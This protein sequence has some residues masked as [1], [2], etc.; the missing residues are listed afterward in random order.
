MGCHWW[1]WTPWWALWPV[2]ELS[3]EVIGFPLSTPKSLST[4]KIWLRIAR[5][6]QTPFLSTLSQIVFSTKHD[7]G[8]EWHKESSIL[9]IVMSGQFRTL[10]S[11]MDY[12]WKE[13]R[14]IEPEK[15]LYWKCV[16]KRFIC[17]FYSHKCTSYFWC[18]MSIH[19]ACKDE[20]PLCSNMLVFNAT[21][22]VAPLPFL[23]T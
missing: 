4:P 2:C 17:A 1:W 21:S 15:K 20:W 6:C 16:H 14:A 11:Q 10:K 22:D 5:I 3:T 13:K 8:S 9:Y 7:I 19:K 12:F 18:W 23:S